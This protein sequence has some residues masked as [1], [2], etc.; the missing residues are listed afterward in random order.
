MDKKRITDI[1]Q[2]YKGLQ[3]HLMNIYLIGMER[4]PLQMARDYHPLRYNELYRFAEH[5]CIRCVEKYAQRLRR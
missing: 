2:E 3:V 5:H 4:A 1:V